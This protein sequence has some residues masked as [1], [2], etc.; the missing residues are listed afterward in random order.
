MSHV[1]L[2]DTRMHLKHDT[3]VPP[4]TP[5]THTTDTHPAHMPQPWPPH[6]YTH[7]AGSANQEQESN[8]LCPR[9]SQLSLQSL[10]WATCYPRAK[11]SF[12]LPRNLTGQ[13]LGPPVRDTES[14]PQRVGMTCLRA[15]SMPVVELPRFLKGQAQTERWP[16]VP[17]SS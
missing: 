1:S 13:S 5:H 16:W 6:T 4:C 8:P 9:T 17:G 3:H 10:L 11:T 15:Q 2:I 7:R 14:E 12:H